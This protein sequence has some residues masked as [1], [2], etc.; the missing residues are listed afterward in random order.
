MGEWMN[1]S[2]F[3]VYKQMSGLTEVETLKTLSPLLAV[4][5]ITGFLV[6]TVLAFVLPLK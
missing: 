4:L 5:G 3:W 1:D 6:S 2:A